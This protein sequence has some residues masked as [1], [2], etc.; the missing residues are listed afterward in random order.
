MLVDLAKSQ[1][2]RECC[3]F[4]HVISDIC[5]ANRKKLVDPAK[6]Q[7]GAAPAIPAHLLHLTSSVPSALLRPCCCRRGC[8]CLCSLACLPHLRASPT[9]CGGGRRL[10]QHDRAVSP[11]MHSSCLSTTAAPPLLQQDVV[12]GDGTT[13]VTVLCGALLKKSLELLEKGVS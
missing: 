10:H 7:V 3:S 12:A 1:V 11:H 6:S 9:G 8:T 5:E 13:S 4:S 2:R